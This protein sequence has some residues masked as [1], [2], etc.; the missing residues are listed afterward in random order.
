MQERQ[1]VKS[2]KVSKILIN[3]AFVALFT[4]IKTPN[5]LGEPRVV[6]ASKLGW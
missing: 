5:M 6:D 2:L 4:K 3:R 1:K